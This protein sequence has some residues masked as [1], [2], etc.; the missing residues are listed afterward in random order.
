MG[1]AQVAKFVA[2]EDQGYIVLSTNIAA[3]YIL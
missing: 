1:M 2:K 3:K